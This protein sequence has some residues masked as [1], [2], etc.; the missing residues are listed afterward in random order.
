MACS[1]SP[2]SPSS[3]AASST[4]CEQGDASAQRHGTDCACCHTDEFGVSGSV[5]LTGPPIYEV[6]VTAKDGAEFVM[7]PNEHGNFFRHYQPARPLRAR[8]VGP[9]GTR[10]MKGDAPTGSCNSCHRSGGSA[11]VLSG[12]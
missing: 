10:E 8:V 3:G 7:T 4:Q 9:N 1:S 5:D 6:R 2:A 12:R 11:D